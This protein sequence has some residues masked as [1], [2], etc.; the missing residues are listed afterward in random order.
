MSLDTPKFVH[1]LKVGDWV[2]FHINNNEVYG[3]IR[4][5][6]NLHCYYILEL[7]DEGSCWDLAYIADYD[8]FTKRNK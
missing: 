5:F 8:Y 3:K 4:D 2:T 7:W 6:P 1:P